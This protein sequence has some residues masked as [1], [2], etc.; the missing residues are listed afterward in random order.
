MMITKSVLVD[1]VRNHLDIAG[2]ATSDPKEIIHSSFD[3]VARRDG[4]ILVIKVALNA[5]SVTEKAVSGMLTLSKTVKGS[6][7]IVAL[8]SGKAGIEDGVMYTRT[9]IPLISPQTLHDLFIEGVPPMVYAGSGGFYV[10]VDSDILKEARRRGISLGELAE[11]SGVQR[12]TIQMYEEGMGAK[13]EV[14]LRLEERLGVELILPVDPL[15]SCDFTITASMEKPRGLAREV[16]GDLGRI[17][18]SVELAKRCPYDALAHDGKVLMFTGIDQKKPDMKK[19]AKAMTNLSR[20]LEKHSVIFVDRM[21]ERVNLEG[22]P[23]IGSRELSKIDDKKRVIEL[24][25]ERG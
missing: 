7:L 24:I 4:L 21:G 16:Y 12:R 17:G 15:S 10:K 3:L 5:D 9:N 18:Y 6:P 8:K 19:R 13:L 2:F 20:I 25:E 14:A 1:E 22:A 23:L 11:A